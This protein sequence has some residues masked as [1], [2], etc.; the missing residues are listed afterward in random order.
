MGMDTSCGWG[1]AFGVAVNR[2]RRGGERTPGDGGEIGPAVPSLETPRVTDCTE[3]IE[4]VVEVA[5]VME[6]GYTAAIEWLL[7]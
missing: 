4:P 2:T 5:L 1:G 3:N 7:K 6:A